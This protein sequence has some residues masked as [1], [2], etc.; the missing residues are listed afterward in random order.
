MAQ[1]FISYVRSIYLQKDK[2]VFTLDGLPLDDYATSLGLAGAPQLKFNLLKTTQAENVS[3]SEN[4]DEEVQSDIAGVFGRKRQ[5]Q[6]VD[7]TALVSCTS[8]AP[9]LLL[10]ATHHRRNPPRTK[11]DKMFARKNQSVLSSHYNQVVERD[12]NG[13]SL[14]DSVDGDDN[15]LSLK[16]ADHELEDDALP[17][18]AHIS[19]RKLKRGQSKKAMMASRPL[20]EKVVFDEDGGAHPIIELKNEEAFLA[21]GPASDQGER[22]IE[23]EREVLSQQ[24]VHDKERERLDK[25]EKKRRRREREKAVEAVSLNSGRALK[26]Q[27]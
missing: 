23:I 17:L 10:I 5:T 24:D 11:Y 21:Q 18:S 20:A 6:D 12:Q 1:A 14:T 27:A 15:L 13:P 2:T 7:S 16:R 8:K 26:N 25:R 9:Q 19:K 3:A 4:R 22:F